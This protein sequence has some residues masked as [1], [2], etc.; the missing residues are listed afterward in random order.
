MRLIILLVILLSASTV[1]AQGRPIPPGVRQA[2]QAEAQSQ[3]DIPPPTNQKTSIDPSKLK[4]DADELAALAQSIPPDVDKTI[5]G[6]LPSD[7]NEKLKR[8]EKLSKQLR[9]QISR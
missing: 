7:L 4:H 9:S 5:K 6:V 8:I 3:K 1:L 2:D